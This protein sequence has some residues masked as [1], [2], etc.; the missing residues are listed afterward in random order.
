MG[1]L[2]GKVAIAEAYLRAGVSVTVTAAREQDELDQ[3]ARQDESERAL[4]LLADSGEL[5][6]RTG[7]GRGVRLLFGSG[8]T[9]IGKEQYDKEHD[10]SNRDRGIRDIEYIEAEPDLWQA[11]IDKVDHIAAMDK[12]IHN[13]AGRATE[14]QAK[15]DLVDQGTLT[16][17]TPVERG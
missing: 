17:Q 14:D 6:G 10:H 3:L 11:E 16:E 15:E 2:D 7:R 13:I 9:E 12:A 8:T 5:T 4:A 1:E